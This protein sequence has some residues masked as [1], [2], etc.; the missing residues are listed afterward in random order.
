MTLTLGERK[1]YRAAIMLVVILGILLFVVLCSAGCSVPSRI[2]EG[3]R[4]IFTPST[5]VDDHADHEALQTLSPFTWLGFITMIAGLV[6]W[7]ILDGKRSMFFIGILLALVPFGVHTVIKIIAP[8]AGWIVIPI[9]VSLGICGAV[10]VV[11]ML[12]RWLGW[13]DKNRE[14][15]HHAAQLE[16]ESENGTDGAEKILKRSMADAL[17][18]LATHS[19]KLK[20][21]S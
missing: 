4:S 16:Y 7:K 13:D 3:F 10:A 2:G 11:F 17:R 6:W 14:Q 8:A 5:P 1:R 19:P 12:G 18:T 9:S 15:L 21:G 20:R